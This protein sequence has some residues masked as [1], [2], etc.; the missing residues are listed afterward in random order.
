MRRL[1]NITMVNMTSM[2]LRVCD[3]VGK[4]REEVRFKWE[5][6]NFTAKILDIEI[7]FE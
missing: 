5:T 4:V 1:L 3:A 7:K 2:E 6:S